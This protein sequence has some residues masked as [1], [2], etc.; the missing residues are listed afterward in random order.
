MGLL[1]DIRRG[2]WV[3]DG[4][5][6]GPV[7]GMRASIAE[8]A[9][10]I[11]GGEPALYAAREFLDVAQNVSGDELADLIAEPPGPTGD[12][13]ADALLAGIAEH[14]ASTRGAPCPG[15]IAVPTNDGDAA[16]R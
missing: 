16:A 10:R 14:L 5:R 1:D 8:S 13:R 12:P 2:T 3:D 6:A 9:A 4:E 7:P 11:R 15:G